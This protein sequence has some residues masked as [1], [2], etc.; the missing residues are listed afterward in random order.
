METGFPR[1]DVQHDVQHAAGPGVPEGPTRGVRRAAWSTGGAGNVCTDHR[2][3]CVSFLVSRSVILYICIVASWSKTVRW[4]ANCILSHTVC[5]FAVLRRIKV[6]FLDTIV[7]VEHHS[8]DIET[9]VALEM[10]IKRWGHEFLSWNSLRIYGCILLFLLFINKVWW[11]TRY[12]YPGR[13]AIEEW[14]GSLATHT[15]QVSGVTTAF[16]CGSESPKL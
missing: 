8:L 12:G 7:R 11:C 2:D 15:L 9:G 10:R 5:V 3:R 4:L 14:D 13:C 16:K 6:T 1:V